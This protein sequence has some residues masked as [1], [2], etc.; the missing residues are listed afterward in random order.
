MRKLIKQF[1]CSHQSI[2]TETKSW[3]PENVFIVSSI[4]KCSDCGK[5]FLQHPN[6]SC[7]YVQHVHSE[8]LK[9]YW[10]EKIKHSTQ[11]PECKW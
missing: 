1:L 6:Q 2:S 11:I 9:D 8:I 3:S 10:L 7:C 4:I 5:T